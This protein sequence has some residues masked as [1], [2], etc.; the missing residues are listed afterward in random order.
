MAIIALNTAATGLNALST[1]LDVIANNL[2]NVNTVGFKASRANFQDLFYQERMQP[3]VENAIGDQRPTGLFVGLG[4]KIS[5]TQLTFAE[6]PPEATDRPLD[7]MIMGNGFFQVQIEDD[8]GDGVG[9]TRAGNFSLNS[10]GEIVMANDVGRRMIPITTIDPQ[11]QSIS[12]STDGQISVLLPGQTELAVVGQIELAEFV[13][14]GGLR[15]I[16]ENIYVP[17]TASGEAITGIPGESNFGVIR[18]GFLEGSNVNPVTE[19]VDLIQTQR[20]FEFNSQVIKA[21]DE[22]LQQVS[23]LRRF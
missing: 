6:G 22:T 16:G 17:S 4:T 1:S 7:M 5:G 3:G 14:P 11:A 9:Y 23:N 10:E 12:V 13:N 8:I 21:A 19:L 15:Q 2:A 18:Q 20:A